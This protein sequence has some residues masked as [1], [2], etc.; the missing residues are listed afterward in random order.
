MAPRT[1]ATDAK[2]SLT[3]AR[4]ERGRSVLWL[5]RQTGIAYKRLLGELDPR[6]TR[7]LSLETTVAVA[8]ALD[9][10]LPEAIGATR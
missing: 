10:E 7:V 2:Q 6:S 1:T 9:M 3:D 4:R 5:S 8:G